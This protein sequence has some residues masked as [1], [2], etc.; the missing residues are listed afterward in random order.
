MRKLF[1]AAMA[2]GLLASFGLPASA[3]DG[4]DGFLSLFNGR[5][6]SGWEGAAEWFRAEGGAI[7]AG[8]MERPVPRNEFLVSEKSYGDF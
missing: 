2:I 4:E 1:A 3:A 5:D 6:L 7:V 8:S